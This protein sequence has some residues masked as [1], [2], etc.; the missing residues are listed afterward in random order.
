MLIVTFLTT[1]PFSVFL[2]FYKPRLAHKKVNNRKIKSVDVSAP[3]NEL[4]ESSLCRNISR[5]SNVD[6]L[7]ASD[8][9]SLAET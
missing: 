2:A 9:D 3:V 7:S 1:P 5:N 8:L 6:I 4:A